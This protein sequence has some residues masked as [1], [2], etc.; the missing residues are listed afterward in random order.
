M[1]FSM[2]EQHR[3]NWP[4]GLRADDECFRADDIFD[5]GDAAIRN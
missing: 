2:L 3:A 1:I 5:T 4:L